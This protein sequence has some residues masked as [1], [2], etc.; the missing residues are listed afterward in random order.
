MLSQ[1]LHQIYPIPTS[2]LAP[3]NMTLTL[4]EN[5]VIA[6]SLSD[7]D[8]IGG[9]RATVITRFPTNGQLYS[10]QVVSGVGKTNTDTKFL[11]SFFVIISYNIKTCKSKYQ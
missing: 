5:A 3:V 11:Q 4:N 9:H 7:V 6:Q 8:E 10:F 2:L 1:R